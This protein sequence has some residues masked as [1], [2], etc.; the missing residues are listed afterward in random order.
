MRN[1]LRLL[2][3]IAV[4][5]LA[6]CMT[7][8][9]LLYGALYGAYF[10]GNDPLL[11][12]HVLL[13][14]APILIPP[15]IVLAAVPATLLVKRLTGISS[16]WRTYTLPLV[17]AALPIPIAWITLP[18]A[19]AVSTRLLLRQREQAGSPDPATLS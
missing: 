17:V 13:M 10:S 8:G 14:L 1:V 3:I 16:V 12:L 9:I 4:G 6:F 19:A 15:G 7:F 5:D 2:G 11:S 18:A